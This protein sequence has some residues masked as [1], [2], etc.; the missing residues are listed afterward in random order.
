MEVGSKEQ[1]KKRC[2]EENTLQ[3][4]REAWWEI[5]HERTIVFP[6]KKW[7]LLVCIEWVC[8]RGGGRTYV[9]PS[10]HSVCSAPS[11]WSCSTSPFFFL[12]KDLLLN[13]KLV[14]QP[15]LPSHP[16][17]SSTYRSPRWLYS[18]SLLW[19]GCWGFEL[20]SWQVHRC[21]LAESWLQAQNKNS[22]AH[23]RTNSVP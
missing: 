13:L 1:I 10:M 5:F 21:T 11:L 3:R 4:E 17:A 18:H 9:W 20:R 2:L 19:Y 14:W 15:A 22:C 23:Q 6:G 12:K 7:E 8:V 16:P